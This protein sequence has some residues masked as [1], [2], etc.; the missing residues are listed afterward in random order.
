LHLL[1]TGFD[2]GKGGFLA[3]LSTLKISAPLVA[4]AAGVAA[5]L[6]LETRASSAVGVAISVTTIPSSAYL[7][8]AA[9]VGETS[10]AAGALLVLGRRHVARGRLRNAADTALARPAALG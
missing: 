1:P 9:G 10:K 2:V 4:L 5:I 6:V 8:V 7:G 3:G